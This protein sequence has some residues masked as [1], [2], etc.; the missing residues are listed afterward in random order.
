MPEAAKSDSSRPRAVL[1]WTV[2]ESSLTPF[3]PPASAREAAAATT[4]ADPRDCRLPYELNRLADLDVTRVGDD[5]G[6]TPALARFSRGILVGVCDF[7][8]GLA[9]G[10]SSDRASFAPACI[11]ALVDGEPAIVGRLALTLSCKRFARVLRGANLDTA[12]FPAGAK[13]STRSAVLGGSALM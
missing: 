10:E 12:P 8:G 9:D 5:R 11:A 4:G 2:D 13:A 6:L 3:L 7:G 1:M